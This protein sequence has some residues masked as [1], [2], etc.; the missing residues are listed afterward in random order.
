MNDSPQFRFRLRYWDWCLLAA[1]VLVVGYVGLSIWLPWY[2]ERQV[3]QQIESWGGTVKIETG[4]PEWLRKI[5]G[6]DRI[7]QVRLLDRV[8]DVSLNGT[9][10]SDAEL[11]Y[12]SRL[13][14]LRKLYLAKTAV[15]DA[16][17]VHLGRL[18]KL[19]E[20]CLNWTVVTDAGLDQLNRLPTIHWL[21]LK[22]TAV[23]GTGF[24]TTNAFSNLEW[25][26]LSETKVTDAGLTGLSR[27][28]NLR[29]LQLEDQLED[30]AITAKG[31]KE[32]KSAL[33]NCNIRHWRITFHGPF[34]PFRRGPI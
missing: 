12:L 34:P 26:C 23:T 18:T 15:T 33:P 6:D 22:G 7:K 8:V 32:L 2:R 5:V 27:L 3:I 14:H 25:L 24:L 13:T 31:M 9:G 29:F 4:A 11:P 17:L 30:A 16:G 19:R 1:A 20:L 21:Y 10:I 28:T